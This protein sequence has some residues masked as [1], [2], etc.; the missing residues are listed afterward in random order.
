MKITLSWNLWWTVCYA[1]TIFFVLHLI[2]KNRVA[3]WRSRKTIGKGVLSFF[4]IF[5]IAATMFRPVVNYMTSPTEAMKW[6][7]EAMKWNAYYLPGDWSKLM[8][9]VKYCNFWEARMTAIEKFC[10]EHA[11]NVPKLTAQ[12]YNAFLAEVRSDN[13]AESCQRI[14]RIANASD[15][16]W[17]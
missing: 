5:C 10:A 17:R 4:V 11:E 2:T 13:A 7:A 14:D 1:V 8:R 12:G 9:E 6:N 15:T 16:K 3:I